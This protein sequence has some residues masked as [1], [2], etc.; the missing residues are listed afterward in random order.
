MRGIFYSLKV[1][2]RNFL[3]NIRISYL[4]YRY[5]FDNASSA[6]VC[7][8]VELDNWDKITIGFETYVGPQVI[9]Y[10]H[11]WVHRTHKPVYIGKKYFIG[12]RVIIMPGV[13]IGDEVIIGAGSIVTKDIPSNYIAAGNPPKVLMS[14]IHTKFHGQ[15]ISETSL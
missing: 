2:L 13:N 3:Y 8:N 1:K 7:K 4:N 6:L 10:T 15:L 12:C 11:D 14:N 9:I 5:K